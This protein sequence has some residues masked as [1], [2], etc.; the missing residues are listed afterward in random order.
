[1]LE[2]VRSSKKARLW[3]IGGLIVLCVV[4]FFFIKNGVA[5]VILGVVIAILAAAFGMEATENDYDMGTLMETRS[6]EAAKI[7]RDESGNL[8]NIDGF[9][10]SEKIDYNCSDFKTQAEAMEVY[11]R[12]GE[13]G[14]N[15]DTFRLDGDKDGKVC[16]SLPIGAS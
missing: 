7:E 3:I 15:M 6:F 13:L 12:C 5:K 1:M 9:C 16:E 2:G 14:K 8:T 4:L 11:E 10:S